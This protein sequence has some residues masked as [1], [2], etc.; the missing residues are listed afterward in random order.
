ME[1]EAEKF[2]EKVDMGRTA[3][4]RV[5]SININFVLNILFQKQ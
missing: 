3:L 1:E 5:S 4:G 2:G